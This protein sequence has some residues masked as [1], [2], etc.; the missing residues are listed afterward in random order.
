MKQNIFFKQIRTLNLQKS[1]QQIQNRGQHLIKSH[2]GLNGFSHD[3]CL[4]PMHHIPDM[5]LHKGYKQK[6]KQGSI[7]QQ[8]SKIPDM[9]CIKALS[10]R[11]K[12]CSILQ[13]L[14]QSTRKCKVFTYLDQFS[15]LFF[16]LYLIKSHVGR[17]GFSHDYS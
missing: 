5:S 16:S 8:Q 3:Q 2:V 7:M 17:N 12:L 13:Q 11:G 4:S 6:R 15:F 9:S 14:R 10:E 1:T